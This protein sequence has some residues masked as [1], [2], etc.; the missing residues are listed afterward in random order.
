MEHNHLATVQRIMLYFTEE[1]GIRGGAPPRRY[2]W[3]DAFAVCNF[4]EL[5]RQTGE[6][7]WRDLA[8]RLVDQVHHVLGRH[9]PGDRRTGWISGLSQEDGEKHPTRGGLRIGKDLDERT[10]QEP[11]DDQ[12]EW[13][14]DGQYFHYLTKWMHALNAMTRVTGDSR[15]LVWGM[16]LAQVAH[17]KFSHTTVW[18]AKQLYWKMSIDLTRP[19]VPSMGLHDPLDGMITCCELQSAAKGLLKER[20]STPPPPEPA[21]AGPAPSTNYPLDTEPPLTP[22]LHHREVP[23]ASPPPP[24]DPIHPPFTDLSA[25][26]EDLSSIGRGMTWET[27]DLLGIGGLLCDM[28]RMEQLVERGEFRRREVEEKVLRAA[29]RGIG[30]TRGILYLPHNYR[31]PFRELGFSIG[32]HAAERLCARNMAEGGSRDMA[33]LGSYFFLAEKV[34]KHWLEERNQ[35]TESWREHR[36]INMVMLATSL[37]PEEFLRV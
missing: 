36:D 9:R 35:E 20:Q 32:V 14:R 4:L 7:R 19:L 2:L 37:A 21:T 1:T 25:A 27:D 13:E 31:L 3:T 16:E 22:H 34:E 29:L 26:I 24:E 11:P 18:G 12:L 8:I 28:W 6:E 33:R 10:P 5:Y 23:H 15:Y 17:A 30:Q